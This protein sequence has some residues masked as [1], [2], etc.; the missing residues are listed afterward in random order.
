MKL[1]KRRFLHLK[2]FFFVSFLVYR[3]KLSSRKKLEEKKKNGEREDSDQ[4]D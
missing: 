4:E 3:V 1:K 2:S